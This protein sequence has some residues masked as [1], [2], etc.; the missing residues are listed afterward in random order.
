M[1]AELL[2]DGLT[3]LAQSASCHD[4]SARLRDRYA[5]LA[6]HSALKVLRRTA[7]VVHHQLIAGANH[8]V[9]ANRHAQGSFVCGSG[10]VAEERCAK[11][12]EFRLV[13]DDLSV[14]VAQRR[15]V[16]KRI[17]VLRRPLARL[18]RP[19]A[20]HLSA[21]HALLAEG[22]SRLSGCS[23][24]WSCLWKWLLAGLL[25]CLP[26]GLARLLPALL[27]RSLVALL[28]RSESALGQFVGC[29]LAHT[30]IGTN[31]IKETLIGD[32][33]LGDVI[34]PIAKLV[35]DLRFRVREHVRIFLENLDNFVSREL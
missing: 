5:P 12:L 10:T 32:F 19:V 18:W 1:L 8:I 13:R 29:K 25:A 35:H 2:L 31:L 3:N 26:R 27:G 17:L 34:S 24:P 15:Q 11:A 6:I 22:R 23:G 16:A 33:V 14:K 20:A 28:R 9:R 7:P 30:I 4:Q 21:A